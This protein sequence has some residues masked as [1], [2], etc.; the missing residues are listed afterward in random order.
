VACIDSWPRSTLVG[1]GDGCVIHHPCADPTVQP[2]AGPSNMDVHR[3]HSRLGQYQNYFGHW[4]LWYRDTSWAD[5]ADIRQ[6]SHAPRIFI[7]EQHIS[8]RTIVSSR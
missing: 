6:G 1:Y 4:F 2:S 5:H 3:T 8:C 7:T